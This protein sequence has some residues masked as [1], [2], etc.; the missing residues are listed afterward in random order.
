MIVF[1]LHRLLQAVAVM[2]AVGFIAFSLF[3]YV[4]DPVNNMVGLETTVEERLEIRER[5]GLNDP[6]FVQYGRFLARVATG[7]FGVSY[8]LGIPVAELLVDR[9]PATLELSMVAG[10][11]AIFVGV[12]LGV[13]T[14]L[15]RDGFLSRGLLVVSLVGISLPTFLIGILLILFFSVLLG[16]LPSFGRGD[17]VQIGF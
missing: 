15:H 3:T 6:F 9:L 10:L 4:G 7:Q 8:R 16:W 11:F 2:M 12:P 17:V 5:L 13:Y 1:V 14:G